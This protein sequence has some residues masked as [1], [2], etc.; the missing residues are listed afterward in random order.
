MTG[1]EI[2]AAETAYLSIYPEASQVEKLY[3]RQNQIG[4]HGLEAIAK[5]M[6]LVNLRELD[7]RNNQITRKGMQTLLISK[8]MEKLTKLD[9]RLN[10]LGGKIWF[11]RLKETGNFPNA[12]RLLKAEVDRGTH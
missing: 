10:R 1:L 7:L 12:G 5:S 6:V 9:L 4:D 3:L 8:N 11:E 2:N